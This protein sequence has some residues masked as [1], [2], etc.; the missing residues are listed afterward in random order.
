MP[1]KTLLA[2]AL[3]VAMNQSFD[4]AAG[5]AQDRPVDSAQPVT[6]PAEPLKFGGFSARF[7]ADGAF[8]LEGQGWPPF[9]GTWKQ[10]GNEIEILTAGD[11]AGGCDKGGRYRVTPGKTRSHLTLD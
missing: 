9:K 4:S 5:L 8:A 7:G 2:A 11:A 1:F 6:L 3:L 10:E